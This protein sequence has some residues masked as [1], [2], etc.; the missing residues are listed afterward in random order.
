MLV[1]GVDMFLLA[2]NRSASAIG[3]TCMTRTNI[4]MNCGAVVTLGVLLF[5][6]LLVGFVVGDGE[7]PT[8]DPGSKDYE[9]D[10]NSAFGNSASPDN[11]EVAVGETAEL[12]DRTL[13]VNEV[14]R[15]YSPSSGSANSQYENESLLVYMV[16]RNTGDRSFEYH[17]TQ[18]SIRG[19]DGVQHRGQA[20]PELPNPIRPGTLAPG[21]TL[22]GTFLIEVPLNASEMSIVYEPFREDVE[23]V[24]VNL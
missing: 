19:S 6:T 16:L 17:P 21:G 22:E 7:T 5:V 8:P 18:F 14:A 13:L 4:L 2:L 24:T 11:V 9:R 15:D 12:R 1:F 10:R 20:L 23:T 3:G